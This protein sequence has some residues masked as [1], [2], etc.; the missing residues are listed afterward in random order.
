M[1]EPCALQYN[2]ISKPMIDNETFV[3][4]PK[5][6]NTGKFQKDTLKRK[7]ID[8]PP[9]AMPSGH[10]HTAGA[11]AGMVWQQLGVLHRLY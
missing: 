6:R 1:L 4:N 9:Y 11:A 10:S 7:K 2:T 3:A 8:F 5:G